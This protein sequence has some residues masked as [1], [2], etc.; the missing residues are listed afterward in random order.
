MQRQDLWRET[1][2]SGAS[3]RWYLITVHDG[4]SAPPE[5]CDP[6]TVHRVFESR[7]GARSTWADRMDT[8]ESEHRKSI[9]QK[10]REAEKVLKA[11][12]DMDTQ[13]DPNM[14]TAECRSTVSGS[15]GCEHGHAGLG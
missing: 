13:V 14:E 11:R 10:L 8:G 7:E 2:S 6:K 5:L 3:L 1:W 12:A 9:V 15:G 4:W